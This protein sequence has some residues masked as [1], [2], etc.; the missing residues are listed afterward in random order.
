ML[1]YHVAIRPEDIASDFLEI[2]SEQRL[3]I[4]LYLDREKSNL[5]NLARHF[6]ATA[7]EIHRNLGR[8]QKTGIVK[9]DSDGKYQLTLYGKTIC[10]Q[11][12]TIVFMSKNKKYFENHDFADIPSKHIQRL[13]ALLDSELITG[14]VKVMEQWETIYKNANE[15]ICNILIETPYNERLLKILEDKLTR[16]IRISSIFSEYAIIPKER[17]EIL[18]KFSFSKFVKEGLLEKRMRKGM[19]FGIVLNERESG[20]SFP[21]DNGEP[22]LSRMFYSQDTFFH[23]WCLDFFNDCWKD[24]T[25]F[26]EVKLTSK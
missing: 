8:L 6:D 1:S 18:A 26:Q 4:I 16:K 9:K 21:S 14:Y 10:T 12:P 19:K 15:Y 11:I 2:S 17:Q 5:A 23:E 22:D 7:P 13:G 20:L 24:A 3:G 25:A